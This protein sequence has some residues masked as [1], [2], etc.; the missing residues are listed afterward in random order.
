MSY[1]NKFRA[2]MR[3]L[4]KKFPTRKWTKTSPYERELASQ[5]P[6]FKEMPSWT[7]WPE[8]K[9]GEKLGKKFRARKA[10][11]DDLRRFLSFTAL[12][13]KTLKERVVKCLKLGGFEEGLS[14]SNAGIY[15]RFE[16][17]DYNV[18]NNFHSSLKYVESIFEVMRDLPR[19]N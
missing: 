10:T 9:E 13:Q 14:K 2:R 18:I 19:K 8:Y 12:P 5:D 1:L 17:G 6:Y 16:G 3:T 11:V 15:E 7:R 4:R